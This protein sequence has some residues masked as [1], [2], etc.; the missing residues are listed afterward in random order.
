MSTA[1]EICA[2]KDRR[3][4]HSNHPL[5]TSSMIKK[6]IEDHIKSFPVMKSHYKTG[7]RGYLSPQLS[8]AEMHR[9]FVDKY[10]HDA[11][12]PAISYAAYAKVFN[13]K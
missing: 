2:P 7:R 12:K 10:E 11:E 9:L 4:K 6:Q 3:G 13:T 1:T 8:I 5:V